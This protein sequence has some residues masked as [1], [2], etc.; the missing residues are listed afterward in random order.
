MH[1]E[2]KP[3]E[4][5]W[6]SVAHTEWRCGVQ[7]QRA[8]RLGAARARARQPVAQQALPEGLR[9]QEVRLVLCNAQQERATRWRCGAA[10]RY[11]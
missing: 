2:S 4:A 8:T 1:A 7:C 3:F 6:L 9:N 5:R 10:A 11:D